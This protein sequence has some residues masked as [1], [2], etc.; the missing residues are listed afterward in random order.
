M[1]LHLRLQPFKVKRPLV[2]QILFSD[3]THFTF[4]SLYDWTMT[5]PSSG[6]QASD[7]LAIEIY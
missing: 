1:T 5:F 2:K 6:C 3:Q 7:S 4:I